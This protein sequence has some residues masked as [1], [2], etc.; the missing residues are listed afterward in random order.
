MKHSISILALLLAL[1]TTAQ[2]GCDKKQD[3]S[4]AATG[5]GTTADLPAECQLFLEQV[6]ALSNCDQIPKASQ[7]GMQAG[8]KQMMKSMKN[9]TRNG[10]IKGCIAGQK[11]I[12][13]ARTTAGC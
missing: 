8:F 12:E 9:E 3:A 1:V 5:D 7:A 10:L 11:A 4:P 2:L 13:S 6:E